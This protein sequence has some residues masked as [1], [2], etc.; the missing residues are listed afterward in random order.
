MHRAT[1]A[2]GRAIKEEKCQQHQSSMVNPL[3]VR[4]SSAGRPPETV[5]GGNSM[6]GEEYVES[7]VHR[8]VE[9]A[10]GLYARV[11]MLRP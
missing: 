7:R 2:D 4:V 5:T 8:D 11:R 3:P 6:T 9:E 10:M 1:H